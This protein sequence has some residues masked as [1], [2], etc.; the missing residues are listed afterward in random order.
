[1]AKTFALVRA[2]AKGD[3]TPIVLFGY[4]TPSTLWGER[5]WRCQKRRVDGL[6]VVDLPPEED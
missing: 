2:F 3:A 4:T 5:F 6:L 1:M